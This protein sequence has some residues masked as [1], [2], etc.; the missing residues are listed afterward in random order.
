[1]YSEFFFLF[2]ISNFTHMSKG[3]ILIIDDD[4]AVCSSLKLL[5]KKKGYESISVNHP[6]VVLE[7]IAE[8]DPQLILLD[9]NFTINTTG[10]Q[11][12]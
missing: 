8:F 4:Q 5:L 6:S 2:Y 11:G 10:K 1:M 7:T 9:M 12:W 3:K